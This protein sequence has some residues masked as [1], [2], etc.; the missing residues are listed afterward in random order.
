MTARTQ[1]AT[2]SA[3]A[4]GFSPNWLLTRQEA[5]DQAETLDNIDTASHEDIINGD[6][7]APD[8]APNIP[9]LYRLGY[10]FDQ[11][12]KEFPRYNDAYVIRNLIKAANQ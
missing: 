3:G 8:E 12:K 10:E 1:T 6:L 2:N 5:I 11:T 9:D 4:G 7:A